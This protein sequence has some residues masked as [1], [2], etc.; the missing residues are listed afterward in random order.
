MSL[1]TD[2]T[3]A[4]DT[5][6]AAAR[7]AGFTFITVDN[8]ADITT[9]M[10]AQADKGVK[11]FTLTYSLSFQPDDLRLGGCLWDAFKT[12]VIQGLAS[13]DIMTNEVTVTLNTS[14][15]VTTRVDLNFS[16]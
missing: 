11:E 15:Q 1:R 8:L 7:T 2:Y 4:L 6:L 13:E 9:Q 10:T 16:F 14:D 12:G 3:G 5:K